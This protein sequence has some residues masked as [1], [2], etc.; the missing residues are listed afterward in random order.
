MAMYRLVIFT[1]SGD[2]YIYIAWLFLLLV[3]KA[4]Y[5]L[6][7]LITSCDGYVYIGYSYYQL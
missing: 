4:M 6:V 7:I 5:I 2:G 3:A 1:T